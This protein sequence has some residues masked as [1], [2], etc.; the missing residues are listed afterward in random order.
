[1]MVTDFK[2]A[3]ANITL[4]LCLFLMHVMYIPTILNLVTMTV[5]TPNPMTLTFLTQP[6]P[7]AV[8]QKRWFL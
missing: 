3:D 1:M 4:K 7:R 8:S 6:C 5:D 2:K